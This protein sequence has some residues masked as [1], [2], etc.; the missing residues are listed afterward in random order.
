MDT[1]F[2]YSDLRRTL[3]SGGSHFLDADA[4]RFFRSRLGYGPIQTKDKRLTFFV[5]SE[6]FTDHRGTEG[7]RLY[8]VR[9]FEQPNTMHEIG[10]F[11]QYRS[12]P[13]AKR[14]LLAAV[15]SYEQNTPLDLRE[16]CD[17]FPKAKRDP[18]TGDLRPAL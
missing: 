8:T 12:G 17:A 14:A 7:V 4:M 16:W 10:D 13:S 11:Q 9:A 2:D 3:K 18:V 5:T 1:I 6:Q 15:A